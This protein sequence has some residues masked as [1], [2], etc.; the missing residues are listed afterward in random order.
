MANRDLEFIL[1]FKNEAKATMKQANADLAQLGKT[2]ASLNQQ[3]K[4]YASANVAVTT[5]VDKNAFASQKLAMQQAKLDLQQQKLILDTERLTL[6]QNKQALDTQRLA[7]QTERLTYQ[8]QQLANQKSRSAKAAGI[9]G[10]EIF[11]LTRQFIPLTAAMAALKT[12]NI[13]DEFVLQQARIR[14]AT[15]S[16]EEFEKAFNGL[17]DISRNTGVGIEATVNIFQRLSFVRKE[18]AATTDEMLQFTDTVAKLGVISGAS[19]DALKFGLTQLGQSLSSNLVRAEEFNSIMENIPAVGKQIADEFGITTGQL[20]LLVIEGKVLSSDVFAAILNSSQKVRAEFEKFPETVGR[21]WQG[22]LLDLG[23]AING[24]NQ[25]SNASKILIEFIYR[26]GKAVSGLSDLLV[27]YANMFKALFAVVVG[28]ITGAIIAVAGPLERLINLNIAAIN[29]F[30]EEGEK[31]KEVDFVPDVSSAEVMKESLDDAKQSVKEAG[32]A[33]KSAFENGGKTVFGKAYEDAEK[34]AEGTDKAAEATRTYTNNYADLAKQLSETNKQAARFYD[35]LAEQIQLLQEEARWVG[36]S[37]KERE[38]AIALT[39]VQQDAIKA[40][41]KDFDPTEFLAAYDALQAAKDRI[42]NDFGA[43]LQAAMQDFVENTRGMGDLAQDIF[44]KTADGISSTVRG[45]VD[46][47]IS[48]FDELRSSLAKIMADI[49]ADIL[50]FVIRQ[51]IVG[52][53]LGS[54]GGNPVMDIFGSAQSSFSSVSSVLPF[55]KG[56]AI[57]FFANGG[58]TDGATAF[59]MKSGIGVAGE[60]GKE[61]ILPLA[62]LSNGDLGVQSAGGGSS[63]QLNYMPNFSITIDGGSSDNG[64]PPEAMEQLSRMLDNETKRTV[65]EILNKE[66]RNG[67]LL[68]GGRSITA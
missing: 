17:R 5:A 13:A 58:I 25:A 49:A 62:R 26:A 1:K 14:N 12:I 67:G 60:A 29:Q 56:G 55:A 38:R 22:F 41:I 8:Q 21:A 50:E 33:F 2:A 68:A 16:V 45:L 31:L 51:Q 9:F 20:R 54:F 61:A 28:S 24:L 40:G 15:D 34:L 44:K 4:G 19:P 43:G 7:L 66:L 64:I 47:S 53:L 46:G 30:R 63:M 18:I 65:I 35:N 6:A 10:N 32:D 39:K 37:N 11:N 52:Q 36:K 59:P 42:S 57:Q 23:F 48:S 27:A 3:L